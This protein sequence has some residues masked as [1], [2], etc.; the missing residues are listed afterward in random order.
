MLSAFCV[1]VIGVAVAFIIGQYYSFESSGNRDKTN[2]S[3]TAHYTNFV[4]Q[5]NKLADNRLS[6][7][8]GMYLYYLLEPVMMFSKLL[9]GPT[10]EEQLITRHIL[11]DNFLQEVI[12]S[13]EVS[14][15]IEIASGLSSR[16]LRF[17]QKYGDRIVY[18]ESD[19]LD[20]IELKTK[21]IGS[22]LDPHYHPLVT[23]DALQINTSEAN[24]LHNAIR[25][26]N[27]KLDKGLVI[28]TEGLL[29]YYNQSDIQIM[30]KL[31]AKELG[32]FNNGYYIST[33]HLKNSNK[34]SPHQIFRRILSVFVRG[35]V[36]LLFA[37][38]A[39]VESYLK[40]TGFNSKHIL[41]DYNTWIERF[42]MYDW[43]QT[44][45]AK[46]VNIITAKV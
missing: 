3:P 10:I 17:R 46:I 20:M 22:S 9:N 15:I 28:I 35:E 16:G 34:F 29:N 1:V 8:K 27:L 26:S 13:G 4:W 6:T 25:S 7:S 24:S 30:W 18:V 19:L 32:Q 11:I 5:R 14:Q 31:F 33:I 36:F 41:N 45:G 12:D 21:L 23:I 37:N 38:K 39:E 44:A 40:Q 42:K 43:S 2:I